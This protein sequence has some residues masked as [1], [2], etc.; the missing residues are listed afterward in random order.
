M[1]KILIIISVSAMLLA[2]ISYAGAWS[3]P[4]QGRGFNAIPN[5][6]TEQSGKID[7]LRQDF[8]KVSLPLRNELDAKKQELRTLLAQPSADAAALKVKQKEIFAMQQQ[9]QEK[10]LVFYLDARAVLTP[11]QVSG[12]PAGCGLGFLT[13]TGFGR[14]YGQGMGYGKGGGRSK[15]CGQGMGY[16]KGGGRGKGCGQ[17]MGYGKGGGRGKGCAQGMGYGKGGGR[18]KGCAQGMG[19]GKGGG[20]GK[21]CRWQQ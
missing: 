19:Y 1:K 2:V 8:I 5:L 9:L 21:G 20:R 10:S 4:T 12:M 6:T 7:N 14:G 18:G 13:G 11:E 17:G 3:S 16:G 15:G